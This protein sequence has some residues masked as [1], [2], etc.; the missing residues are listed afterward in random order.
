MYVG[1]NFDKITL[2]YAPGDFFTNSSGTDVRILKMFL[3]KNLST[4]LAFFAQPTDSFFT[5]KSL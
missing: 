4:I 5:K 1:I 2:G 3:P